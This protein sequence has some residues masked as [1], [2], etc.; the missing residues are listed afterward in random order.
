[1]S[2]YNR[3]LWQIKDL[4]L[5]A[6]R[7]TCIISTDISVAKRKGPTSEELM[8]AKAAESKAAMGV[9]LP[10]WEN[11]SAE[12]R[13]RKR[14]ENLA[15]MQARA[16]QLIEAFPD[17][18]RRRREDREAALTPARR[19]ALQRHFA[20][21]LTEADELLMR[22]IATTIRADPEQRADLGRRIRKLRKSAGMSRQADLA[23]EADV[24][25]ETISRIEKGDVK[26]SAET[27]AKVYNALLFD[28]RNPEDILLER[29]RDWFLGT[30]DWLAQRDAETPTQN[31][32]PRHKEDLP[33]H[34][35]T[36]GNRGEDVRATDTTGIQDRLAELIRY[37]RTLK[38]ESRNTFIRAAIAVLDA[39]QY[40]DSHAP[41]RTSTNDER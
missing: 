11:L 4:A 20:F 8:A 22:E 38:G 36:G 39:F 28:L 15:A 23:R 41:G 19:A 33:S 17:E 32:L 25:V 24:H 30:L 3:N 16:L 27:L 6:P 1:M 12:E 9:G 18:E 2:G 10:G 31:D 29:K 7:E 40:A 26:V 37:V 21:F 13:E 35:E 5:I 14:V 34:P